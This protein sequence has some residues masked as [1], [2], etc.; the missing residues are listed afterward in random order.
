MDS[1]KLR[2]WQARKIAATLQ[3]TVGYLSRLQRR[4]ELTGF[5]P[6]DPLY[7][8]TVRARRAAQS[9]LVDLHYL[10]CESGVGRKA[11][12]SRQNST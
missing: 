8:A 2:P 11:P 6:D 3:P 5:P 1:L 10:S 12:E 4:M 7:V 9:L